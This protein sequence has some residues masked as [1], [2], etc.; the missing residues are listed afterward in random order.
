MRDMSGQM[1]Y[2]PKLKKKRNCVDNGT[3]WTFWEIID[4]NEFWR[5]DNGPK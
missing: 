4:Q 3:I 1:S 5:K 2:H